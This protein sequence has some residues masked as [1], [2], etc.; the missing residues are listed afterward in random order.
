[1]RRS[2]WRRRT[3][4]DDTLFIHFANFVT[5]FFL[6]ADC[7]PGSCTEPGSRPDVLFFWC[8]CVCRAAH[9]APV[10]SETESHLTPAQPLAS[11][12]GTRFRETLI[13]RITSTPVHSFR[14]F[15]SFAHGKRQL[16]FKSHHV[17]PRRPAAFERFESGWVD[18]TVL[19]R[20]PYLRSY[21][22]EIFD[23]EPPPV[24]T[25]RTLTSACLKITVARASAAGFQGSSVLRSISA[26]ISRIA[27]GT[28]PGRENRL[29][30]PRP[31]SRS[32][33][34][35]GASTKQFST[36]ATLV[37]SGPPPTACAIPTE[38]EP[39]TTLV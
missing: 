4:I 11:P 8:V 22:S 3:G 33:I 15:Q 32:S 26:A 30:G 37:V 20:D 12:A 7:E 2:F 21:R 14:S 23:G 31:N 19:H 17:P 18:A 28:T 13:F 1:V 38:L 16:T 29:T 5:L 9:C 6:R 36:P 39:L 10:D 27:P 24:N 25:R 34:E 35:S